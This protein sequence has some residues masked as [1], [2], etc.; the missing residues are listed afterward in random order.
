A[1][2][3]GADPRVGDRE[4]VHEARALI[5][6][7]ERG[8]VAQPQVALQEDPVARLEVIGGAGAVDDAVQVRGLQPGPRQRLAGRLPRERH[9]GLS[10]RDPVARLDP[11]ALADPLVR[12][13]H[14]ARELVVRDDALWDVE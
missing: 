11:R 3:A 2:L 10:V 14:E 8:D 13:V 5:A 1:I 7:V 12:R 9:A 4:A 6:D